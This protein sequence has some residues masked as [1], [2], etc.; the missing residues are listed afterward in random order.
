MS[1]ACF[2]HAPH[3]RPQGPRRRNRPSSDCGH[4][5]KATGRSTPLLTF[6]CPSARDIG[7]VVSHTPAPGLLL[8]EPETERKKETVWGRLGRGEGTW[9]RAHLGLKAAH[10][11]LKHSLFSRT[12]HTTPSDLAVKSTAAASSHAPSQRVYQPRLRPDNVTCLTPHLLLANSP[13]LAL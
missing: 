2:A 8:S 13:Q 5:D 3:G 10:L 12:F 1:A 7:A 4:Q 6:S 9:P 11:W